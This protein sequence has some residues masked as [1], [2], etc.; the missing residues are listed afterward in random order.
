VKL[1]VAF[2]APLIAWAQPAPGPVFEVA[3]VKVSTDISGHSGT[4]REGHNLRM[5][6]ATLRTCIALAYGVTLPQ[7][8]GPEWLD[9]T[10]Y[11]IDAKGAAGTEKQVPQMLQALLAERFKLALH[12]DTRELAVYALVVAKGGIKMEK[13]KEGGP[14][15]T[16]N[17]STSGSRGN[18][19]AQGVTMAKVAN[20]LSGA[21]FGLDR[22]VLDQ[23]GL[24]DVYDF[25]LTWTPERPGE[26][27]REETR[28]E[29]RN[30]PPPLLAA[31]QEQ[32]GLKLEPRKAPIE[33]L[34][35]D[36][37]EKIPTEN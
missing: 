14:R 26:A 30:A 28:T 22:P 10:G 15:G 32:L 7:V 25:T 19:T 20:V 6:N 16:T 12:R 18:M 31:L 2:F 5:Q 34:I 35:V 13:A 4:D 11:D 3:S 23:T 21:R 1:A 8:V 9:S 33:V 24:D 29:E 36:H 37:A 17:S 27:R